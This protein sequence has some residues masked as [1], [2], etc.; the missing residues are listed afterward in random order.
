MSEDKIYEA[1]DALEACRRAMRKVR[2]KYHGRVA[3][4]LDHS[5]WC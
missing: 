1:D 5:V 2:E 4:S 3:G